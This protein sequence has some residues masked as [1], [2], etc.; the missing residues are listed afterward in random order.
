MKNMEYNSSLSEEESGIYF[1]ENFTGLT[2]DFFARHKN[3]EKSQ[4]NEES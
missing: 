4:L 3:R 1:D 2:G